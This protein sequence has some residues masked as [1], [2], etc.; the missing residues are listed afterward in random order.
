[1]QLNSEPKH[2]NDSTSEWLNGGKN[3]EMEWLSQILDLHPIEIK[4][5]IFL[6]PYNDL[7]Q[8]VCPKRSKNN[9]NTEY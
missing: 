4:W 1:M 3:K 7:K 6:W 2:T 8:T 9:N 5:I